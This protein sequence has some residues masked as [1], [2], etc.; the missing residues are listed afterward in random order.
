MHHGFVRRDIEFKK[1]TQTLKT[2]F[3]ATKSHNIAFLHELL[4]IKSEEGIWVQPRRIA[5]DFLSK[6][7]FLTVVVRRT[8]ATP[9]EANSFHRP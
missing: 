9:G 1:T 8:V 7:S 4:Q 2:H 5:S 3:R 6:S